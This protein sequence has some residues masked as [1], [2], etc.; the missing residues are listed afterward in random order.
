MS[1]IKTVR[2]LNWERMLEPELNYGEF[3]IIRSQAGLIGSF[4]HGK[5]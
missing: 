3:A 2:V 1:K 5:K 4:H